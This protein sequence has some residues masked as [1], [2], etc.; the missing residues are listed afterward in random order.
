[1]CPLFLWHA[2]L[3]RAHTT[4]HTNSH[5][6]NTDDTKKTPLCVGVQAKVEPEYQKSTK[7]QLS[8][9][10]TL[11]GKN[12]AKIVFC[13]CFCCCSKTKKYIYTAMVM[14]LRMI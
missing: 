11:Y 14:V 1:V 3:A 12:T 8:F 7:T 5:F 9:S 2:R 6:Q 4:L 10:N 13:C